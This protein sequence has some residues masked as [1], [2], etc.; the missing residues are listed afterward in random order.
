MTDSML[1]RFKQEW[2][3]N[4]QWWFS[5]DTYNDEVIVHRYQDLLDISDLVCGEEI[6]PIALVLVYDQLPRHV[7]RGTFSNHIISYFLEK[8]LEVVCKYNINEY[9]NSLSAIEWTFFMLPL[10]HTKDRWKIK[11]VLHLTWQKIHSS[12]MSA[13]D[14]TIYKRFLK[15]TYQRFIIDV[16]LQHFEQIENHNITP[17]DYEDILANRGEFIEDELNHADFIDFKCDS[18]VS[19]RPVMLSLSGGVDSMVCSWLLK[20]QT[21]L[22]IIA[23]HINYDNR[24]QCEK[25]VLFLRHW[26]SQLHIP[27][28]VK[29]IDEIHRV[30]CMKHE[31]RDL[32]ESYTRDVR[33]ASYKTLQHPEQPQVILGHNRDDCLENIMTNICHKSKYENLK[34]MYQVTIQD[35]IKFVRPLLH[36]SKDVIYNFA[37]EHKIPYLPNSTPSWSQRGQIRHKIIPC[38]NNWDERFVPSLFSLTDTLKELHN[39]MKYQVDNFIAKGKHCN[40]IFEITTSYENIPVETIFWKE[41]FIKAFSCHVSSKSLLN[42]KETLESEK[43]KIDDRNLR[44][45]IVSKNIICTFQHVNQLNNKIMKFQVEKIIK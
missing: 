33:Y 39:I 27:L 7:F 32:Y 15:A 16:P 34:G 21:K 9:L 5:K 42:M 8:A 1:C 37:N 44:K 40:N 25:E 12:N 18:I 43:L 35:G 2:F 14:T 29:K 28:Y 36:I 30:D 24:P 20:R 41:F 4:P 6:E 23:V 22:D 45:L 19:S 11:E 26:C 38:L 10:R 13:E 3:A 17:T 31:L